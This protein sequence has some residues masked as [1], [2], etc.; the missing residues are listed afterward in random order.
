M[1]TYT[2]RQ[3][4]LYAAVDLGTNNCRLLIAETL[5]NKRGFRVRDSFSRIVKLGEGLETTGA[6]SPAAQARTISALRICASKIRGAGVR[7]MRCIATEACRNASNGAAFV[8]QIRRETGLSFEVISGRDEAKLAA[9]GCGTLFNRDAAHI[10]VFDIGGGS[11]EIIRLDKRENGRFGVNDVASLPIGVVRLAERHRSLHYGDMVEDVRAHFATFMARQASI[12]DIETLQ[13]IGT[14]G[15]VTTLSAMQMGLSR[16]DRSR[17]DGSVL[18]AS[19]MRTIIDM[20]RNQS[21]DELAS[22]GCV[23]A[24]RVDFVVAGCAVLDA[25]HE[26]FPVSQ[27][28]VADRGLRDGMLLRMMSHDRKKSYAKK[29]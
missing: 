14:S 28:S 22:H 24:A 8:K 29:A 5:G 23:G 11:T 4:R 16:Y 9:A 19:H 3:N 12:G 7:R 18:D 13:M 6:L 27:F 21:R 26:H 20:V 1:H 25:L 2:S 17:V 15:T 10:I